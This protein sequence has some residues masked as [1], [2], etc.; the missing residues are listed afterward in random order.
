MWRLGIPTRL[1]PA[2][3]HAGLDDLR[4]DASLAPATYGIDIL[5]ALDCD[6]IGAL[7]HCLENMRREQPKSVDLLTACAFLAACIDLDADRAS[8]RLPARADLTNAAWWFT[9]YLWQLASAAIAA[10]SGDLA[11]CE[12]RLEAVNRA[13]SSQPLTHAFWLAQITR[14]RARLVSGGARE[15]AGIVQRVKQ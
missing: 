5:V 9:D 10:H 8:A 1:W 7:R 13:S 6:D 11:M 12:A 3:V 14:A 4:R 2:W 15:T